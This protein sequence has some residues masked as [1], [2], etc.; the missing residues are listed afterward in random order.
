MCP[1]FRVRANEISG[2]HKLARAISTRLCMVEV[3][4]AF[5]ESTEIFSD[6]FTT[7]YAI[8]PWVR[9]P[10]TEFDIMK[11][12]HANIIKLKGFDYTFLNNFADCS[13][14][15]VYIDAEHDYESV[16]KQIMDWQPKIKKSG[17]IGGH[18]YAL[19]GVAQAVNEIFGKPD[20]VYED[21]SWVVNL[22][23]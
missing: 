5:G 1:T 17:I 11:A 22:T 13:L 12:R 18:D 15:F 19:G 7:V 8:D 16:K 2:L 3:G 9:L 20:R 10:D 4:C 14:D 21:T 6:Y 23:A